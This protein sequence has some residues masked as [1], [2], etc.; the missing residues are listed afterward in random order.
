MRSLGQHNSRSRSPVL[1]TNKSSMERE[2]PPAKT[3]Q[4][5]RNYSHQVPTGTCLLCGL[6]VPRNRLAMHNIYNHQDMMFR[7]KVG[8]CR[9]SRRS[10]YLYANQL[11]SHHQDYHNLNKNYH[12]N[13]SKSMTGLPAC[14]VK[15]SCSKCSYFV[16]FPD[17]RPVLNHLWSAHRI[18]GYPV[19]LLRYHCRVCERPFSSV[20]MVVEHS[21]DHLAERS[22]PWTDSDLDQGSTRDSSMRRSSGRNIFRSPSRMSMR[23]S[24]RKNRSSSRKSRRSPS[25][26]SK[27]SPSRKSRR[28]SS[29]KSRKSPSRESRSPSRDSRRS[30]SRKSRRSPSRK[31]RRSPSRKSRRSPSREIRRSPSMKSRRSPCRKSRRSPSKRRRGSP[32]SNTSQFYKYSRA[33]GWDRR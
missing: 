25:R 24:N 2:L 23:S 19:S 1:A 11:N 22:Q 20:E 4:S 8:T 14:M 32:P 26:K 12:L 3:W 28:S 6:S 27:R 15:I 18:E 9:T 13:T 10:C 16:L 17:T 21:K 7:C 5:G 29:R 31:S 30:S 33:R